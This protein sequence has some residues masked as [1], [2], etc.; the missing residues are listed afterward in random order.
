M[1]ISTRDDVT[2]ELAEKILRALTHS[3]A[4]S[5]ET[6]LVAGEVK[7]LLSVMSGLGALL[8]VPAGASVDQ[9]ASQI[10]SYVRTAATAA[11][12]A[13]R[14]YP[15]ET[16]FSSDLSE[17]ELVK[18]FSEFYSTGDVGGRFIIRKIVDDHP[19]VI[20]SLLRNRETD[21]IMAL[22]H[23]RDLDSTIAVDLILEELQR[24]TNEQI[25]AMRDSIQRGHFRISGI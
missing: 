9:L 4:F 6:S 20:V 10:D 17:I 18:I 13:S 11:I 2:I 14:E 25:L 21:S 19:L 7:H 5:H 16:S 3:I 22:A 23:G 24:S 8:G 12:V 15:V 1:T